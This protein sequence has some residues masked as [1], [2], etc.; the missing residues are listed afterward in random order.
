MPTTYWLLDALLSSPA[1]LAACQPGIDACRLPSQPGESIPR[2]DIDKLARHDL[3]LSML[4]EVLRIHVTSLVA[5]RVE[6]DVV[7][8]QTQV[9]RGSVALVVPWLQH[10]NRPVWQ[11]QKGAEAHPTNEFWAER[12]LSYDATSPR[13]STK[14]LGASFT[15]FGEGHHACPGRR[16]AT[17]AILTIVATLVSV[18]E[19]ESLDAQGWRHAELTYATFGYTPARPSS[20]KPCRVR[21]RG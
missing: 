6:H 9:P 16:F 20:A 13:F 4:H 12:F 7:I 15:P 21:R 8:G 17:R 19:F 10:R 11:A 14:G 2:F 1:H 18:F 3:L 5:R